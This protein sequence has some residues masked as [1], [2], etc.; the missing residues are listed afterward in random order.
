MFYFKNFKLLF[1]LIFYVLQKGLFTILLNCLSHNFEHD[2]FT[3]YIKKHCM[4]TLYDYIVTQDF[5]DFLSWYF[6][7]I[8]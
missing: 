6:K 5:L 4:I 3:F 2:N 8:R 1:L 7:Q